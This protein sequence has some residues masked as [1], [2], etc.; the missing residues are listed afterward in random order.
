VRGYRNTNADGD[1]NSNSYS[2]YNAYTECNPDSDTHGNSDD[3]AY[4]YAQ[5]DTEGSADAAP[6]ADSV[7][8]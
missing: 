7:R 8:E 3:L 6:P 1:C 2:D 5:G 4:S